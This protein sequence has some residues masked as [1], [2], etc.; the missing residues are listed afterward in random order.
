LIA[1]LIDLAKLMTDNLCSDIR[2]LKELDILLGKFD[3]DRAWDARK[4]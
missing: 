2:L 1:L 3:V 4:D